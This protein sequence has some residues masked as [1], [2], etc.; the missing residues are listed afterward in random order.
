[1][2]VPSAAAIR[3]TADFKESGSRKGNVD[4]LGVISSTFQ[5]VIIFSLRNASEGFH[6]WIPNCPGAFLKWL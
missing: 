2:L 5:F 4:T 1:M 3:S 6:N